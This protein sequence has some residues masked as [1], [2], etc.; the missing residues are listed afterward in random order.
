MRQLTTMLKNSSLFYKMAT[1]ERVR[2]KITRDMDS[3]KVHTAESWANILLTNTAQ[4]KD[5]REQAKFWNW[6]QNPEEDEREEPTLGACDNTKEILT[7]EFVTTTVKDGCDE[8][9]CDAI[10]ELQN[11]FARNGFVMVCRTQPV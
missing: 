10:V 4:L 1:F 8:K 7:P 11:K 9:E 5:E 2:K 6:L 3:I